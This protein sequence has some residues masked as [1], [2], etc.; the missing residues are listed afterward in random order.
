MRPGAR[1]VRTSR[2]FR[3]RGRRHE[4]KA[5]ADH[6]VGVG[7]SLEDVARASHR[8][9]EPP[10][11]DDARR[12]HGEFRVEE[13]YEERSRHPDGVHGVGAAEEHRDPTWR[14][15]DREEPAHAFDARRRL[16]EDP[17]PAATVGREVASHVV[18]ASP[19]G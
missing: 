16:E 17:G 9:R 18:D 5:L 10:P 7:C 13:R 15:A 19:R 6:E 3:L 2:R 14:R 4:L 8:S 1:E 11:R 12:A